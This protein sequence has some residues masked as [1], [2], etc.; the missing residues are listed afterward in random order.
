M[1]NETTTKGERIM[2][3]ETKEFDLTYAI[4]SYE[5]GEMEEAQFLELFSYLVTTGMA[6]RLQGCY[7][8]MAAAL[9]SNHILSPSG[10][11]LR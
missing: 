8:R 5:S 7:G 6:W 10:E 1:S 9:I 2:D 4:I 3:T 11:V